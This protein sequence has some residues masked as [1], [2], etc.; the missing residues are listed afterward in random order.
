MEMN[1]N[2]LATLLLKIDELKAA[3]EAD[4]T[5]KTQS[6]FR[7]LK[8]TEKEIS[9]MPKN[10]RK[11]MRIGGYTVHAR[12]RQT[13]RYKHS[14]EIR[15]RK[16]GYN[17]SVSATTEE[18]AKRRFL[19]KIK[20][21]T[22]QNGF[23]PAVPKKFHEFAVY[24][25]ENFHKRKVKETTFKESMRLYQRHIREAFG[26]YPI[27]SIPPAYIQKFLDRFADR[28][29]TADELYSQLNQIFNAAVNHGIIV[30]N[31]LGMCFHMQHEQEHGK[32]LS[33]KEEQKLLNAFAGTPFQ[34]YFAIVLY[35]GM[36]P[37]EFASAKIEGH[38]IKAINS[39]RKDG[40]IA[41]KK[42]PISPMLAPFLDNVSELKMPTPIMM[43]KR[44]KKILPDHKLY[45][46]RTTF[47][48]RCTECGISDTAIGLFMGN[49]IGKLKEAYTDLSDEYLLKEGNKLKY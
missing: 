10:I 18:E 34:T 6:E 36:R 39:K 3:V 38:F 48:T 41:Y 19:E 28:G 16:N 37:N 23:F 2:T 49:S 25:F 5:R 31:P 42:I 27:K 12:K 26:I 35:T 14:I 11:L 46:L 8:F 7:Y 15:Y 20:E 13:G 44:F 1:Q 33:K 29:K 4:P 40:K 32:A 17:I 24:W 45:D 22:P 47:Q 21:E 43:T 30:R 9:Q